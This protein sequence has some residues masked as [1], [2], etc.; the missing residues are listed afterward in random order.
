MRKKAK[1]KTKSVKAIRTYVLEFRE[2]WTGV[3]DGIEKAA[4]ILAEAVRVN[5]RY[6]DEFKRD[7]KDI[8]PDSAWDRLI[9]VGEK[10]LHPKLLTGSVN[11]SVTRLKYI[12]R[13]SYGLQERVLA[14]EKFPIVAPS[15]KTV[16]VDLAEA[17][18]RQLQQICSGTTLR[19][20]EEQKRWVEADMMRDVQPPRWVILNAGGTCKIWMKGTYTIAE[21]QQ[22]IKDA[23]HK[24]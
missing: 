9:A 14:H 20:P 22:A 11:G 1:V 17:T 10:Q 23:E 8:V 15:G 18:N 4:S 24:K 3:L 7:C 16:D 21:L 12:A 5:P 2:A 19:T 13:L 6:L